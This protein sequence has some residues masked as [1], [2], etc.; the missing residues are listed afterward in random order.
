V[1]CVHGTSRDDKLWPEADWVRLG[2]R[3]VQQGLTP[4]WVHGNEAEEQRARRLAGHLP[5]SVIWPR[6]SLD[7]L[8]QRM[9][10]ACGVIG[11]DSGLSHIA[12]ALD[13][14]HVQIYNF[15]TAWRTGPQHSQ[16]QISVYHQPAPAVDEVWQAW[17]QVRQGVAP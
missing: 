8:A 5:G 17:L 10:A 16:R 4:V 1:I 13:L 11:V 3:L 12:V 14:P 2:Q 9:A 15:D 6:L 7:V